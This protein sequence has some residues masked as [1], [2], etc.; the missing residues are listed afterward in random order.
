MS[1]NEAHETRQLILDTADKI[2][3]D[4]CDKHLLDLAE[5][6]EFPAALWQLVKDN[7]FDQLGTAAT[8]TTADDL[9]AFVQVCGRHAVPLPLSETLLVNTWLGGSGLS[10]FGEVVDNQIVSVPWGR[11]ADRVVGITAQSHEVVVVES[12]E[13]AQMG[14]N[15]AG[16]PSDHI[17]IP[18][19]ARR[20]TLDTDPYTVAALARVN[21]MAGCLQTI[22]QLGVR[23]ATERT[24]FGRSI[25]KF[26]A[27]QHSLAVV[28]AEAAA[29]LRASDAAV[30]ALD[31]ERFGADVAAA[32]ARVGEAVGVVAEQVHQ[33]H[34]AM[35]FTH[36]HQL[37]HYTRRVWAWR[38]DWGNEFYWQAELGM[39]LAALGADKVWDFIA[40][41]G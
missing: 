24:Q 36:E 15:M 25:S 41:R 1:D 23:F 19:D 22:L 29:A 3:A 26:Q 27:I 2:F 5:T 34:G 14:A 33:I 13:V 6:G 9:F 28:A 18:N 10:S 7:G 8:G 16:E 11:Q 40:T 32:K 12:P 39:L 30:D 21:Q 35:G 38:D 31:T 17:V 20:V 4:N 37:H